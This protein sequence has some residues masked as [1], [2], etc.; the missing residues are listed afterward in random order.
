MIWGVDDAVLQALEAAAEGDQN[1]RA[2]LVVTV[3]DGGGD[4]RYEW[5]EEV[6]DGEGEPLDPPEFVLVG[7]EK[8]VEFD[9]EDNECGAFGLLAMDIGNPNAATDPNY[10]DDDGNP[11]PDCHVDMNDAIEIVSR[12]LDCT[13][14]QGEGCVQLNL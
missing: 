12:W 11:L 10:V 4:E 8:V 13:D 9:I 14:P 3:L 5:L 1:Y 7:L 6:L 2:T